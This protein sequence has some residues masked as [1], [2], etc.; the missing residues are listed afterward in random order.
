[1]RPRIAVKTIGRGECVC[2]C[3]ISVCVHALHVYGCVC[4]GD[5][6][7]DT[8]HSGDVTLDTCSPNP[9]L[10][11]YRHSSGSGQG[12]CG[13]RVVPQGFLASSVS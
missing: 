13:Q 5:C 8:L 1:M 2:M 7:D 10:G 9:A 11:Q 4:R 6:G 12:S 3:C